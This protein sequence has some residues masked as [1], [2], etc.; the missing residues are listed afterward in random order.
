MTPVKSLISPRR[1]LAY[2]PFVSRCSQIS[3]GVSTKISIKFSLIIADAETGKNEQ[4]LLTRDGAEKF[5]SRGVA[6]SPDG[7]IIAVGA[8]QANSKSSDILAIRAADGSIEKIG[9]GGWNNEFNLAWLKNGGGPVLINIAENRNYESLETWLVSYP[10]GAPRKIT[11]ESVRYSHFSL[12]VSGDDKMA[13]LALHNNLQIWRAENGD[14]RRPRNILDGAR[15]RQE[16]KGGLAVAPD[17]R[18]FYT[19]RTSG[20][21]NIC[22]MS[23]TGENQRQVTPSQSGADDF[24]VNVT[25]DN[26]FLV[27]V[28]NR[29]GKGEIWRANPYGSNLKQLTDGGKNIQATISPDGRWVIYTSFGNGKQTLWRVSIEGGEPQPLTAEETSWAAVSPD[30]KSIACVYEKMLGAFDRRIAIYPFDGGSPLKIFTA[31]K[32]GALENRLRWSPG[33]AAL[34]YKDRL[35]GLWQ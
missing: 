31:S 7:K 34:I 18:I 6:W 16:G 29:S 10:S 15:I 28:S 3:S 26:R 5:T 13:L 21:I 17:G 24:Q 25:A 19:A 1:A 9:D 11:N 23:A 22:E 14:L 4:I 20:D 35:L 27:F 33:G 2:M 32:Y 12:S 30:G 8:V